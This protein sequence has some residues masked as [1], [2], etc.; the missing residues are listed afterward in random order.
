MALI[1]D[2]LFHAVFIRQSS[3]RERKILEKSKK[4]KNS[5][6]NVYVKIEY[7]SVCVCVCVCGLY[8]V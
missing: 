2:H 8:Y 5:Q 6:K 1:C 4:S 3:D 7:S